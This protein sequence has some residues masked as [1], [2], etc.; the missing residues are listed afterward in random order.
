MEQKI[1]DILCEICP[2]VDFQTETTLIDDGILDSFS[3]IQIVTSL[4]EEFDIYID[5]DDIEP[6]NLNSL[7][8]IIE[9]VEQKIEER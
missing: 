1:L 8:A 2:E 7:E 6:E 4:M 9:L 3:V 5:A